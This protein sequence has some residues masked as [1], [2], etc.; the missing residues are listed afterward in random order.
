M[1]KQKVLDRIAEIG[2]VP[3]VRAPSPHDALR[4]LDAISEGGVTVVE[5]TMTVP[6]AIGVI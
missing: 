6:G 5:I 2:L 4:A 3:V 1:T